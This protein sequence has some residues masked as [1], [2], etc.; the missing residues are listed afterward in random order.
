ME[1]EVITVAGG[2]GAGFVDAVG[3]KAKFNRPNGIIVGRQGNILVA[4]FANNAIR[5][6]TPNGEVS[7]V[8]GGR[9]GARQDGV[10]G[11]ATFSNPRGLTFDNDGNLY[12]ADF[13]NNVLRKI[14]TT[15]VVSTLAGSGVKGSSEGQGMTAMFE[16]L[17]DVTY[18]AGYI[19]AADRYRVRRVSRQGSVTSWAGGTELGLWDG[20]AAQARFGTLSAIAADSRGNIFVVDTDNIAIR[21]I[22]QLQKVGTLA[23]ADVI[24][25]EGSNTLLQSPVGLAIDQED[26]C[27][28]TDVGDYT[29]KKIT[30]QGVIIQVAGSLTSGY[31]DG[32]AQLAQFEYPAGIAV[33]P[34]GR[35]YIADLAAN[36]LRCL[37]PV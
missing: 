33:A 3:G 36:A 23:G 19:F 16:E 17:R 20:T 30:P 18:H 8:A 13:G 34:D 27:W 22:T 28:V 31:K 4:D 5:R 32:P 29:V 21:Y 9:A 7:T 15:L 35:I 25:L 37:V 2:K 1:Y 24:P 12:V 6:V 11:F 26:N 14:D 10:A